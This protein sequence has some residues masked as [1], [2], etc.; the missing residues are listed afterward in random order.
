LPLTGVL[1][2]S[3]CEAREQ[4]VGLRPKV[5]IT[6]RGSA[7]FGSLIA[8]IGIEYPIHSQRR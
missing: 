1:G 5:V 2:V 6:E 8:P 4:G 3:E 7:P